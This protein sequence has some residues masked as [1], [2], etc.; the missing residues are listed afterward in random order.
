[1]VPEEC[2]LTLLPVNQCSCRIH[3]TEEPRTTPETVVARF[4]ARFDSQC[5][6]CGHWI[7]EGDP[8]AMTIDHE[9]IC[10]GCSR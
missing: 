6:H 1:M 5:P 4:D 8:I 10:G 9:Y 3:E 2:D 7:H